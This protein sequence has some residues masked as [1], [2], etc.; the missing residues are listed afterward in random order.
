MPELVGYIALALVCCVPAD[1]GYL[2]KLREQLEV[3]R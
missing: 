3:L 1:L 2:S